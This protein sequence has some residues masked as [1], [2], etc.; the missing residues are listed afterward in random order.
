MIDLFNRMTT[1]H[2]LFYVE[3]CGNHDRCMFIFTLFVLFLKNLFIYLFILQAVQ[4]NMNNFQ[5]DLFYP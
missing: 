5:T 3:R 2:G 4:S 1:R